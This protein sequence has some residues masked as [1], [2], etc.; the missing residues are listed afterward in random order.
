MMDDAREVYRP[1]L[2]D[3]TDPRLRE[4]RSSP[5]VRVLD[6][7]GS[8][9][10]EAIAVRPALPPALLEESFRW[11][12]YPWRKTLLHVPGPRLYRRLRLDRNRNKITAP[13]QEMFA[14]IVIG[15]AG[16]SVGSAAASIL[17]REGLC[18][19]LLLADFDDIE[20]TNLNR[21]WCGV[22]EVGQNKAV[23]TARVI[24]EMDPYVEVEVL[25][26]GVHQGN[27]EAFVRSSDVVLD[28]CDSL[29][30]KVELRRAARAH[31]RPVLM[32][33]SDRGLLDVERFDREPER[34]LFHGL[35]PALDPE[36]LAG[37]ST[38]E[39][40]PHVLR[41]LEADQLSTRALASLLEID[42][43]VSTWPQL[44]SDVALGA[45]LLATAVRRL[46]TSPDRLESG[47]LR[48]DLEACLDELREPSVQRPHAE[49]APT[50]RPDLPP[51]LEAALVEAAR[52]A[53]SGG[54]AQPWVLS[55]ARD[56]LEIRV[57]RS[58]STGMDVGCRGSFVA[59][60]AAVF[61]AWVVAGERGHAAA[62]ETWPEGPSADLVARLVPGPSDEDPPVDLA[63]EV[64][65]RVSNR[66]HGDGSRLGP[67]AVDALRRE[68]E[69]EGGGLCWLDGEALEA[70]IPIWGE[71][72]RQRFLSPLLHR[73][74]MSELRRPGIDELET[75]ID[76]RTL[77]LSATDEVKLDVLRRAD[78]M[79]A[80][81]SWDGGTRLGDDT[82]KRLRSSSGLAVIT[83]PQRTPEAYLRGGMAMERVW[84]RASA[85]GL[86]VQPMS[87]AFLY[88]HDEQELADI[89]GPDRGRRLID[90]RQGFLEA[91]GLGSG[92]ALILALRVSRAPPPS[93]ISL[94]EGLAAG[95]PNPVG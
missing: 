14:R 46:V 15:I 93:A 74:M 26:R 81:A 1:E 9:R 68:A 70:V 38:D 28:E 63:A 6:L 80:L 25:P 20:L 69:S 37:L 2:L 84:L 23:A 45:S 22:T 91:A 59:A 34:P 10:D 41:M 19:K 40:V 77:E 30:V 12:H 73:E 79:A 76:V 58:R 5:D 67:D 50:Q 39:K 65:R 35:V 8:S 95:P 43:Q 51:E 31:R 54:N 66:R 21:I 44:A 53:P 94:R 48:V 82:V 7:E 16:L 57:D 55:M 75:G 56:V 17:V 11:I 89:V 92:Q 72:D 78:V 36:R 27:L 90:L 49:E 4:L 86:A 71:A 62:V 83:A 29:D 88:A 85:L 47:R 64:P 52:Y 42:A 60:G 24:A 3:D 61:N 33:T 32:E 18:G 87:P 13:E